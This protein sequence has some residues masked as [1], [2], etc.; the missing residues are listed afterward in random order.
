VEQ[1][2]QVWVSADSVSMIHE[3]LTA[4]A[5]TGILTVPEK[6][7]GKLVRALEN[8]IREGMVTPFPAWQQGGT[9][10]PPRVK[11]DEAGRCARLLLEQTKTASRGA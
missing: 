1:A 5:N 2:G 11:L 7:P 9:L 3:A 10:Q 6:R 8:L 4:G